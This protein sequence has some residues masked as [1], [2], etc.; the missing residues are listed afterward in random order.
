M[1]AE[2]EM[3]AMGREDRDAGLTGRALRQGGLLSGLET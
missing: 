2:A 1:G 3:K